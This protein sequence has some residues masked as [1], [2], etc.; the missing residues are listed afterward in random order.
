MPVPSG[1]AVRVSRQTSQDVCPWNGRFA[2]GLT[3]P[4]FAPRAALGTAGG[5]E[6]ART[7]AR[8]L[9]AM[10]QA[11][12]SAAFKRSPMKRA[13]R[14]GPARNAAVAL[15]NVGTASDVPALPSALAALG[16]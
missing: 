14:R 4:A 7:L 8:E 12:F 3:E 1:I 9:L 5:V 11:E 16:N 6:D 2:R 15:G 10:S 13:E